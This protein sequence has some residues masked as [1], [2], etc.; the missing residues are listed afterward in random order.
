MSAD[1]ENATIPGVPQ[2]SNGFSV[3]TDMKN[4]KGSI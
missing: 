1:I 3:Y 2:P 4:M